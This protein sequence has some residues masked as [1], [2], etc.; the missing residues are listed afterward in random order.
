MADRFD[1]S[2]SRYLPTL[3]FATRGMTRK[4]LMGEVRDYF[5]IFKDREYI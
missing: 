2:E 4:Y 3:Y 5:G 1:A